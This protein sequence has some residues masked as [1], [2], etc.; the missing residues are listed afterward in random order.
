MLED[1][2][3]YIEDKYKLNC[4]LSIDLKIESDNVVDTITITTREDAFVIR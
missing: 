1:V 3:R 4:N 2:K